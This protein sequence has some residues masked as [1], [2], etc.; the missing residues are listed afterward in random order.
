LC[1]RRSAGAPRPASLRPPA[2]GAPAAARPPRGEP[3]KDR[4]PP[5][6]FPPPPRAAPPVAAEIEIFFDR[7]VGKDAAPLGH[8]D[9]PTRDDRRRLLALDGAAREAD[10]AA[11][12]AQHAGDR[13]VER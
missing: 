7:Q 12:G 6:P 13:A 3:R 2:G 11:R 10:G 5:A 9:E 1:G 8:V 4:K